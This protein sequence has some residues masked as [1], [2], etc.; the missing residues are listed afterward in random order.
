MVGDGG[1]AGQWDN[2]TIGLEGLSLV[3]SDGAAPTLT[4]ANRWRRKVSALEH[5][6]A[7]ARS[8]HTGSR[9]VNVDNSLTMFR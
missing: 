2:A 5:W 7:T 4:S 3:Y 9:G 8:S 6:T 1:L